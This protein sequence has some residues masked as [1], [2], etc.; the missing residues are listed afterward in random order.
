M[1]QVVTGWVYFCPEMISAGPAPNVIRTGGTKNGGE[2]MAKRKMFDSAYRRR[3][4]AEADAWLE[5]RYGYMLDRAP[6]SGSKNVFGLWAVF[7]LIP[8]ILFDILFL[9]K[10]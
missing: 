9:D 2:Y 3:K 1:S 4:E 10:D 7:V 8:V 5:D 6:K